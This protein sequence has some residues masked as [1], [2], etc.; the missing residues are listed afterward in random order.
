MYIKVPGQFTGVRFHLGNFKRFL[1]KLEFKS[2]I[3]A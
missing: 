2:G 3:K 1:F